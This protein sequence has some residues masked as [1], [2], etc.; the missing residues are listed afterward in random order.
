V[1]KLFLDSG[2]DIK[3]IEF[4]EPEDGGS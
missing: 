1:K 4:V 2:H 3:D